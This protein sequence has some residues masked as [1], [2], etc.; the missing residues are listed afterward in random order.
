MTSL[1]PLKKFISAFAASLTIATPLAADKINP[2]WQSLRE[3]GGR[4]TDRACNGSAASVKEVWDRVENQ[5]DFVMQNNLG[6]LDSNCDNFSISNEIRAKWQMK[7]AFAGYPIALNGYGLRLL[8]GNGVDADISLGITLLQRAIKGGYG[9]A[10]LNLSLY[11]AD[12]KYFPADQKQ[13][14]YY[15]EQ[16]KAKGADPAQI[17]YT[18]NY[19]KKYAQNSSSSTKSNDVCNVAFIYSCSVNNQVS[20]MYG[21]SDSTISFAGCGDYGANEVTM[22]QARITPFVHSEGIPKTA[23]STIKLPMHGFQRVARAKMPKCSAKGTRGT[24]VMS[25]FKSSTED[26]ELRKRMYDARLRSQARQKSHIEIM[27]YNF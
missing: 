7:S 11:Y 15:L 16:A 6:W 19:L 2:E 14:Q 3:A 13:A 8:S 18:Q 12:G 1:N 22:H 21:T 27:D 9:N 4:L 10:A 26:G 24:T 5:G 20:F 17:E 25:I 23:M